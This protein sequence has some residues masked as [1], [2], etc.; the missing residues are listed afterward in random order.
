MTH[1]EA[2]WLMAYALGLNVAQV[3]ARN[4]FTPEE[5]AKIDAVLSRREAGEPLQYIMGE[6]DFLGR[7]FCVG[8]GVLIPRADTGTLI[9]GV[10][11]CAGDEAFRFVDW[12]TGS[13]CIAVSILLEYPEAYGYMV[14]VSEQAVEF[15][16]INLERFGLTQRA[17]ILSSAEGLSDCRVMVS[18]PPYIPSAEIEGLMRE[19]RDYEPRSALDGGADGLKFYREIV[20]L[21]EGIGCE[22]LV[23]EVGCLGQVD[24]LRNA[25]RKFTLRE[26]VLDDGGFPRCSVLKRRDNHEEAC[27]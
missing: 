5:E 13:G 1:Q 16:R 18:N 23:L 14:E 22:F 24:F 19:V 15:A 20:A 3:L 6:A 4:S 25:S 2:L 12:G 7:D 17:E 10:R 27:G 8:P 9:E 11:H 26:K 21:A